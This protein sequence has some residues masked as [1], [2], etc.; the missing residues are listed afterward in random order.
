MAFSLRSAVNVQW[1][2][3][4]LGLDGMVAVKEIVLAYRENLCTVFLRDAGNVFHSIAI[5]GEGQF[6]VLLASIYVSVRGG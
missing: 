1:C 5:D 6:A 4:A 3:R 2:N